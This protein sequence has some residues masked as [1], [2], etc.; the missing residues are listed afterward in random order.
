MKKHGWLDRAAVLGAAAA[1]LIASACE[2]ETRRFRDTAETTTHPDAVASTSLTA[3]APPSNPAGGSPFAT[4]AYGLAEGKRLYAAFNCS[5]CHA[6]AG[7][8][9][10]GPPL[11]DDVWIYG[12]APSQ[13]Y[14]TIVQGRPN[15]MPSFAGKLPEQQIWQL[16]AYIESLTAAVPRDVSTSRSD[17]LNAARPE[18]RTERLHRVQTGHR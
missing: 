11:R 9:G 8:G 15:G 16:V 18:M 17:D 12:Y 5:G 6:T 14:S 1:V 4:N 3:G 13:I 10:I 7:G 2:R